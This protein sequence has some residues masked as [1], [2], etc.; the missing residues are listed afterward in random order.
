LIRDSLETSS[1]L[2][3]LTGSIEIIK[4]RQDLGEDR[5]DSYFV[6]ES[7][8][9]LD[10]LSIIAVLRLEAL[11]VS[12]EISDEITLSLEFLRDARYFSS[13]PLSLLI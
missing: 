11:K 7:A 5:G 3:V 13:D 4:N 6:S 10:S 1:Q 12:G 8:I 2:P 9:P